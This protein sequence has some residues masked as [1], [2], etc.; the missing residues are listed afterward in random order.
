M[1]DVQIHFGKT[2]TTIGSGYASRDD[3]H[4]QLGL[5]RQGADCRRVDEFR[6][7]PT[8]QPKE[9]EPCPTKAG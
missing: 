4:W 5:W 6:V 9:A 3:A 7:V 1:Y 8:P 2:W